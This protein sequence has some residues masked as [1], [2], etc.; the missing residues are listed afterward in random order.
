MAPPW[1]WWLTTSSCSLLLIY[2]PR[3]DERLSWP[4]WLTYSYITCDCI[5]T[6]HYIN[7]RSLYLSTLHSS[8]PDRLTS[9]YML[10]CSS[11]LASNV[12]F[13][14]S[15]LFITFISTGR[16]S[17]WSFHI[18][19]QN[20]TPVLPTVNQFCCKMSGSSNENSYTGTI[21]LPL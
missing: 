21:L 17:G 3:K 16:L 20:N 18:I 10:R 19:T 1:N 13:A 11:F 9:A 6:T 14:G 5:T 8:Q 4:S 15:G 2:W 12:C 7:P